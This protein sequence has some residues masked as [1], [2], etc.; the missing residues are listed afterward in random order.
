M[1]ASFSQVEKRKKVGRLLDAL[2]D[3]EGDL[4]LAMAKTNPRETFHR[5]FNFKTF[6]TFE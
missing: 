4:H 2:L 5:F 3:I 1:N 6:G